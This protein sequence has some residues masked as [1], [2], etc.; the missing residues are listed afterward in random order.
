MEK[1]SELTR[2][3]FL[4]RAGTVAVASALSPKA[5]A[6][7]SDRTSARDWIAALE[8]PVRNMLAGSPDLDRI[9][10]LFPRT[11][12]EPAFDPAL[13]ARR[14]SDLRTFPPVQTGHSFLDLSIKTGLAHIDATFQGEHPKYGVGTYAKDIHDGFPPTIIAAVDALSAWGLNTRAAQL[15]R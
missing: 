13:I 12:G 15:F 5:G 1:R 4:G 8:D 11:T 3:R 10:A 2:R 6:A 7:G 9:L 14:V